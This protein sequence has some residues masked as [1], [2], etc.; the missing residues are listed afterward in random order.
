MNDRRELAEIL[1]WLASAALWGPTPAA[2]GIQRCEEYLDEIGNHPFGQADVLRHL[3]GLY[4]MQDD[5][6]AA[7]DAL[8][9]AKELLD[10]LG[11]TVTAAVTQP[12]ALVAMLAGDPATAEGHLRLEYGHLDGMGERRLLATTAAEL[13]KAIA[14]QGQDRHDEALDL[15][16]ISRDAAAGEDRSAQ[17]VAQGLSARILADRGDHREAEELARSAVALAAQADLLSE[18]ADTLLDLAHVLTAAG[19]VSEAH[20]AATQALELYQRKGNL[21]G[22]RESLR[23]PDPIRI[24]LKGLPSCYTIHPWVYSATITGDTGHISCRGYRPLCCPQGFSRSHRNIG[25]GDAGQ[26]FPGPYFPHRQHARRLRR[27]R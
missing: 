20:S 27:C 14:A 9:R 18:Y 25:G 23:L 21:P 6:T 7:Q 26:R 16:A 11:P 10:A 8:S 3:A 2:E 15:L 13:A 22:A 19:R 24:C 5:L 12:A 4:A 17:A 1:S